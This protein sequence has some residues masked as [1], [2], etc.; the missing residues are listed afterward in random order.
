MRV[1]IRL[2]LLFALVPILLWAFVSTLLREIGAAIFIAY[3]EMRIEL[4]S[5][6]DLWHWA[7]ER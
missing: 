6:I 3:T 2:G 7:G 1:L 4:K 5:F